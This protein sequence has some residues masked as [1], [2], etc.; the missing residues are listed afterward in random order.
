MSRSVCQSPLHTGRRTS[1]RLRAAH[2][3][4]FYPTWR[5]SAGSTAAR[6]ARRMCDREHRHERRAHAHCA[7]GHRV[8]GRRHRCSRAHLGAQGARSARFERR[9]SPTLRCSRREA[10]SP[11]T[12][13]SSATSR[14]HRPP[15][16]KVS[17]SFCTSASRSTSSRSLKSCDVTSI[18]SS[19]HGPT[20]AY[21]TPEAM[22]GS[23]ERGGQPA[24]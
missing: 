19:R 10:Q 6:A 13:A 2:H 14:K 7:G 11:S 17:G 22:S 24:P 18:R 3:G 1:S 9:A 23:P 8:D 4:S 20:C 15:P 5:C 21:G 16:P 12:L